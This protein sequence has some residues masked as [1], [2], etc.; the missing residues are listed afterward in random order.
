ALTIEM[1]QEHGHLTL[2]API[3]KYLPDLKLQAPLSADSIT[4]RLLLSHTHGI[5][6]NGPVVWRTAFSGVHNDADLL[7]WMALQKPSGS[8]RNYNYTNIGYNLAGLIVDRVAHGTWKAVMQTEVLEPLKMKRTSPYVSKFDST[9]LAM[10]YI[11]EATGY[12]RAH[13][14]KSDGSM[15]A[16][17]GLVTTANDISRWLRVQINNGKIDGKQVFP[18]RVIEETHRKAV[19]QKPRGG[20][21]V[22][23]GYGLGWA[24]GT[25]HGQNVITHGG[26]FSSFV[27]MIAFQPEQK[28]GVAVMVNES[29][30]GSG[31]LQI[32]T[33]YVLDR[34]NE[35]PDI[36]KKYEGKLTQ[37]ADQIQKRRAGIGQDRARRALRP[38]QLAVP[39]TA[40]VGDYDNDLGGRMN[41]RV[42][43]DR[44]WLQIGT[45]KSITEVFDAT[46]NKLRAELEPGTGEVISFDVADG[47]AQALVYQGMK[48]ERVH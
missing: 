1:M 16:A 44:I 41:V 14:S 48:F 43:G 26:G 39:L 8:G 35:M 12:T 15:H 46:S 37:L 42:V 33:E 29:K 27:T 30:I 38:Q 45:L 9:D 10:P 20:E 6:N 2:D 31:V 23:T 3:S 25:Y 47:K 22:E 36:E 4:L 11:A 13:Y 5:A 7:R 18:A 17:G 28:V 34:G 32:V 40:F 24:L 19:D 21:F